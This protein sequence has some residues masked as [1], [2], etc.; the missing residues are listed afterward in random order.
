MSFPGDTKS[1]PQT[2]QVQPL[3]FPNPVLQPYTDVQGLP[4]PVLLPVLER[5]KSLGRRVLRGLLFVFVFFLL[6]HA[7]HRLFFGRHWFWRHRDF[8]SGFT[9]LLKND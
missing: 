5:K 4:Q 7:T 6:V 9:P 1:S 8:V 2:S 3:L